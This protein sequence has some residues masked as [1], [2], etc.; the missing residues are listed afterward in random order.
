MAVLNLTIGR[1]RRGE[2][3]PWRLAGRAEACDAA[4][5]RR[6]ERALE[7]AVRAVAVDAPTVFLTH[8]YRYDPNDCVGD[9]KRDPHRVVLRP[10]SALGAGPTSWMAALGFD[11]DAD[12]GLAVAVGWSSLPPVLGRGA[13]P[14][15]PLRWAYEA[16]V[17][18]AKA[19]A[20]M[21]RLAAAARPDLRID[22]FAHSLGARVAFLALRIAAAEGWSD[23]IGRVLALG[24]AEYR[25]QALRAAQRCRPGGPEVVNFISRANDP[26]DALLQLLGPR[27]ALSPSARPLGAGGLGRRA[28]GWIDIQL[29]HPAMR[30]WLRSEGVAAAGAGRFC[31]HDAFYARAGIAAL[32]RRILDRRWTG[33]DLRASGVSEAIEPRWARFAPVRRRDLPAPRALAAARAPRALESA[34][35]GG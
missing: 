15:G 1:S 6:A 10:P 19:L 27:S 5:Q 3:A 25:D 13:P 11:E 35:A 26:Y 30:G 33:D 23:R 4:A 24:A 20:A 29:D 17:S 34:Q 18:A 31:R 21:M 9:P 12:S 8:G 7:R 2:E 28:P 22:L 16:A 32:H 14:R